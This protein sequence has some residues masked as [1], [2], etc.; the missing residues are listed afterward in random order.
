[1]EEQS[2]KQD[3]KKDQILLATI[4]KEMK[5]AYLDYAMSVIVGRA[6]PDVRDGLKPVH[7]R[8]LY[9]MNEMGITFSKSF[10][11]SARI[12][13][14]VLG[15]YHPHGDSAVYESLVRMAQ[16]FALRYPLIKGQGNF[17]SIDGDSAAAMRYTEAK[18]AKISTSM[19]TDIEKETIDFRPNFDESLEEPSVLPNSMPNLLV[20]GSNGIAV[21]MATNIPPHNL[22]EVIDAIVALINDEELGI[23]DLTAYIKAPDFPTGGKIIGTAGVMQAYNSGRGKVRVRATI[24][25]EQVRGQDA[26]II[27]EIPYQVNK[28]TLIE[29]I[30]EGVRE[31]RIEHIRDIRDESDR[32][33]M[34]I[35]IE[36]K[37]DANTDVV[38]N[39]LLKHSR[40][41]TTLSIIF[42]AI[43]DKEPKVLNLKEIIQHFI[44]H[45]KEVVTRRTIFELKKAEKKAH[46]LEGLTKALDN[47]DAVITLIKQAKAA[48]D[49]KD[50][51][52]STYTFSEEQ[53][54]AIL[55]MKLQKLTN[56]EQGKIREDYDTTIRLIAE[57]KAI[58]AS[59]EK[60][61][62]IIKQE[63]IQL[64]EQYG[65]ARRTKIE[66]V[67]DEEIEDEDLIPQENQVVT[68]TKSGYA[69]RLPIDTYKVQNRGGKGVIGTSMKEEDIVEHLFIANTHSHLLI[70]TDKGK[71][72]WLK[73]YKMPEGS[74]QA[75]GKALVN[76]VQMESTEK[77]AAV[78]PVNEFVATDYLLLVTKKGIIKKTSLEAYSRPRQ[79]GIIGITLDE[80][81]SVVNVLKTN[82]SQNILLASKHG[83][84][85][86][87]NEQDARP[88]GRTSRGV[89]GMMLEQDDTIIGAV[90]AHDEDTILTITQNGYGKRTPIT[91]YRLINRGGKGVRN[92]I[93]SERNGHVASIRAVNGAE[94]AL[95]ISQK[96]IIIRTGVTQISVIGRNTQGLRIMRLTAGDYVKA[97]ALVQ[98]E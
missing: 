95:L 90:I 51:L 76:L 23:L 54:Q 5:T 49:A 64:K 58:L 79:T 91:D 85:I 42:L 7:R 1:M 56:L 34:R 38:Q 59:D 44:N 33:G 35:V 41:Q 15:K 17:G 55:D 63:L 57:L 3:K 9:A 52:M 61:K 12:V 93:C 83:Q 62:N 97:I 66:Y 73:V 6:L 21:G 92:I 26:I 77:V 72:Y 65:D 13:G 82:G 68:I 29:Q 46:L 16:D 8:I 20:N 86:R 96:G 94:E 30:A 47:I 2:D 80:G 31:E 43:V 25:I 70:F 11:K 84:A 87:F 69:K 67:E 24:H 19:L 37:K 89:R 36:L 14:E 78:I 4:E 40:L 48:Q 10:K 28:T 39:Q 22:S 27:T 45:R 81:D 18:L 50:E 74:R 60:I 88:I 98:L 71:V 53:A 32:T 75:K